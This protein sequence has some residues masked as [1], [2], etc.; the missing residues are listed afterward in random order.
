MHCVIQTD[1]FVASAKDAGLSEDEVFQIVVEIA[2]NPTVGDLIPGTGGA[3]K[4]RRPLKSKAKGKRGG[5]R[6]ISYFAA[7]DIPVFLLDVLSK[8]ERA[9]L[10]QADR[11]ELRVVLGRIAD[12][13]RAS[14]RRRIS[15]ISETA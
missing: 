15:S 12:D 14:E 6:V 13:Y 3:R 8:G 10:S 9:D 1:G 7:D 11:N 2:R 4:W 5:V